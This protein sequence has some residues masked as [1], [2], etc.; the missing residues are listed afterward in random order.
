MSGTFA[1]AARMWNA[2]ASR[3]GE[4]PLLDG[5]PPDV[6][7]L[8]REIGATHLPALEANARA[9][10]AGASTHDL[11]VEGA[12]YRRVPTSPYRVWCLE[13]LRRRFEELGQPA[14]DEVRVLLQ[15]HGCWEPMWSVE[16]LDSG[17]D[18][19]GTAPFCR[20]TRMVRD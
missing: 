9:H 8:L 6:S 19:A 16:R 10:A 14:A 18:P 4:R 12:T 13:Q 5:I 3:L 15:A 2:R 20:V 1:W 7:P 17:H 11:S